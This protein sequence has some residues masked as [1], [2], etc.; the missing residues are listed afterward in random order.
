MLWSCSVDMESPESEVF[1]EVQNISLETRRGESCVPTGDDCVLLSSD[2]IIIDSG[3]LPCQFEVTMDITKC[4]SVTGEVTYNFEENQIAPTDPNCLFT[5]ED[6][7]LAY[8]RFVDFYM[9]GIADDVGPC[10]STLTTQAVYFKA[11][12]IEVCE[13][14]EFSEFGTN[15]VVYISCS[16]FATGCCIERSQWCKP[17]GQNPIEIGALTE[18]VAGECT[19]TFTNGC[20]IQGLRGGCIAERCQD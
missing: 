11:S 15:Y 12:C 13:S 8:D 16:E 7:D 9:S 6:L 18:T 1:V 2:P 14:N 4:V 17:L 3:L 10:S 5:L 20:Q 19:G